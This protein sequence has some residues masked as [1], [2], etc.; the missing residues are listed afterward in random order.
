MTLQTLA[1]QSQF[2]LTGRLD[3]VEA[4]C[5]AFAERW[6]DAVRS[7]VYGESAEGRP[8]RALLVSRGGAFTPQA[9]RERG[10]PL[11]MVQAGI[12]P[13]ESDGK[14][15]GFAA[16]R[17]LLGAEPLADTSSGSHIE[18]HASEGDALARI[19]ILFVP[20]FNTDGHERVGR[21]NRPNQAGPE[22]TGWRA[23]AHNL[24][25]NRDYTKADSPEMRAM[26]ALLRDWDPLV[27]A[28]MHVTDGADFE[29]DVSIQVEPIHLGDPQL[30]PTG[31]ALR[32]A[33]LDKLTAQGSLALP[34]YPEPVVEDDP[35]SGF[36]VTAYSPRYSTGY[37]PARNRYTVLVET[38]SW[39]D[40]ATR[41]R[42]S[43]NAIMGLAELVASHGTEWSAAAHEA[44][45][46]ASRLA[47]EDVVLD[48]EVDRQDAGSPTAQEAA[49]TIEF[50]GYAYT[51]DLSP[52]SGEPVTV[53]DP[54]TPQI[55]HVPYRG[56]VLPSLTV[57]APRGGYL[58]PRAYAPL[59]AD[60]LT[61]H[62]L[63]YRTLEHSTDQ[64]DADV[65]RS[66]AARF[67]AVPFEGRTQLAVEGA[68]RPESLS[69]PA[70][71]LFVPIAQP[72]ARLLMALL[73]P[74]A[75]DSLAAWGFFNAHFEQKE[76]VEPYVT[77]IF[78]QQMLDENPTLADE[79]QRTLETD[80]AFAADP[81]ARR[82]FF[83][84]R[85]STWDTRFAMYPILRTDRTAE[86]N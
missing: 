51:R 57:R 37:F 77:E 29:P 40:Y 17:E 73:E 13:G 26:L 48:I 16:L 84:Q 63:G 79:F 10:I 11:L 18:V 9:L 3:E 36:Q 19:A 69:L 74:Q 78:A 85:H 83:Q 15:A 1:E 46:R 44:D 49:A 6:P 41:V 80:P 70:G 62:G 4:L 76:Y 59:V 7:F 60:R 71:S 67:S 50:R 32:D 27:S 52:I 2:R 21:W 42:V 66:T 55:W 75:P 58:V 28:D 31:T 61:L 53:Y 64:P 68:W 47:G 43:R 14:D 82:E 54:T 5:A 30:H 25:L 65:F 22:E 72:G 23:T 38:H 12:H 45:Q 81:E 35:S 8:M 86:V 34:F 24:N 39:K 56:N 33:L 20:A